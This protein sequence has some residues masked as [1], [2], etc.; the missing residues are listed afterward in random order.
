MSGP[1]ESGRHDGL[2]DVPSELRAAPGHW[3]LCDP[4]TKVPL[5]LH[6]HRRQGSWYDKADDFEAVHAALRE[7][8]SPGHAAGFV[9]RSDRRYTGVDLDNVRNPESGQI[10]DWAEALVTQ[11]DSYTEISVSGRGLHVL[12][13]G[14]KPEEIERCKIGPLPDSGGGNGAQIE[15]YDQGRYFVTTGDATIPQSML[16]G[17]EALRP[18]LEG[19][20]IEPIH[21]ERAAE[22]PSIQELLA[23][24]APKG[25]RNESAA[26]LVG[27]FL[28]AGQDD[29]KIRE[30][31]REWNELCR[32]PMSSR[33]LTSVINSMARTHA[34]REQWPQP[35]PLI[36]DRPTIQFPIETAFP[37][38]L[39]WLRNYV[40]ATA[41]SL[42][43]PTDA[44][45]MTLLPCASLVVSKHAK[46]E[47]Q[48]G[49][50]EPLPIWSLVLMPSG[51]RKS[52]IIDKLLGPHY[53]W[54]RDRRAACATLVA[55]H[56]NEVQILTAQLKAAQAKAV[57]HE[58]GK[59]ENASKAEELA[60]ELA[61]LQAERPHPPSL[62]V[63][64]S[65]TEALA[66][67]LV[68][69][70]ER[71]LVAAPEADALDVL[72]GRY[73]EGRGNFG[74]WLSGHA[75]DAICVERT[76]R[77]PDVLSSPALSVALIVQPDAVREMFGDAQA[78]GRGLIAR[79]LPCRPT[80][81]L[82][83]RELQPP[84]VPQELVERWASTIRGHL[85]RPLPEEPR[86]IG[87]SPAAGA[88]F[89][90]FRSVNEKAL[91]P[92]GP[93]SERADWASKLPGAVLRIAG[94]LHLL[95]GDSPSIDVETMRAALAWVPYLV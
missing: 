22:E 10:V 84:A 65:T 45:A 68:R 43:V 42:Q 35:R 36:P 67:V 21:L 69:N 8:S 61:G 20:R 64:D 87:L 49:W 24:G 89:L 34:R 74:I 46:I 2:Q 48:P 58:G 90:E 25:C 70:G 92:G 7:E 38:A 75:G 27:H 13:S 80:S 51:E 1:C 31:M 12:L 94:V 32:P 37:P 53:A 40:K 57:K 83:S 55:A 3:T 66:Q 6:G 44:V 54:I 73:S 59:G 14:S 9:F 4:K 30:R 78:R 60:V 63:T 86:L 95:Q 39:T 52:A 82:G 81:F 19:L 26:R 79:F 50:Q 33:E 72:R 56:D 76:S 28:R 71:A 91:G 85:D 16:A 77:P 11:L 41:R 29:E 23:K 62:I 93:L 88:M 17:T 18:A 5:T 47:P 15:I